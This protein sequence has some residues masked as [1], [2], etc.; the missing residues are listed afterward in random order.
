MLKGACANTSVC[1]P[2]FDCVVIASGRQNDLGNSAEFNSNIAMH[3]LLPH[4]YCSRSWYVKWLFPS[5]R[6]FRIGPAQASSIY[7][8]G[9]LQLRE[10]LFM[11]GMFHFHKVKPEIRDSLVKF[12]Q[13]QDSVSK[14]KRHQNCR[15]GGRSL[16]TFQMQN[17]PPKQHSCTSS[18]YETF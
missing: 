5:I 11:T 1:R 9:N 17:F 15:L 18:S 4:Y 2:E 10:L 16:T 14:L 13:A 3:W 6:L 7:I 8:N 12:S